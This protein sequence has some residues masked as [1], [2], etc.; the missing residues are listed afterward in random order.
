MAINE[1]VRSEIDN[2]YKWSLESIYENEQNWEADYRY[3]EHQSKEFSGYNGKV[4]DSPDSLFKVTK[5]YLDIDRVLAKLY[6]Y[7]YMRS[8]EDTSNTHYQ[9]LKGKVENLGTKVSEVSSF[10]EPELL[11]GNYDQ[12]LDYITMLPQLEEYKFFYEEIYRFKDYILGEK[13][14]KIISSLSKIFDNSN[15]TASLLRN[16]DLKFGTIVDEDNKE[17]VITNSNYS[18]YIESK[19]RDVRKQA[20]E[21]MYKAYKDMKNTFAATLAG[22]VDGNVAMAKIRGYK[23]A[24]FMSLYS[25]NVS[26]DIYDNLIKTI[27][28]NLD[29]LYK[30]YDLKKSVLKIEELHLYDIYVDMIPANSKEYSFEEAKELVINSLEVLGEDYVTNLKKAFDEKWIDIYPNKG[31]KSGA[32]SWGCYDSKPFILLNYQER[33]DDVSTLAHELGHSMHSYY[34]RKN[35]EYQYSDY[36]IFVAEVASTVNELLLYKYMLNNSND[37]NVK[38]TILNNMLELF[39]STI[40]RQT[41]FAEFEMLIHEKSSNDEVLTHEL[42]SDIYYELNKKYFGNN[43]VVDDEIRYEWSRIPHFYKNFYV[44]QYATGLSAACHIVNNILEGNGKTVDNYLEF[45]KTGGRDYPVELLKIA[46]V[47]MNNPQVIESAIAMFN[48]TIN[49]FIDLYNS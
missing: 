45:L 7:A 6:V 4:L 39:K 15:K 42:M 14:E 5:L 22:E 27:N 43:V 35:N 30:Y 31:K 11:K 33:L 29:V 10:F 24:R 32:Y 18:K 23:D 12:I 3:V 28:E 44:Y 20:F 41:M 17:V 26:P 13:E 37:K 46:G 40:Y 19:N 16:S 36:K 21:T 2:A 38:L 25:S 49:E 9:T 34:S 48:D 1:K 8:D 47:D